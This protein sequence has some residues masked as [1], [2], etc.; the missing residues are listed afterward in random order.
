M[1][2]GIPY[3][4]SKK[5]T[6]ESFDDFAAANSPILGVRWDK[7]SSPTLTRI[8]AAKGLVANVGVD[9]GLV[10]NDFDYMPIFRDIEEVIDASGNVFIRIPRFYIRKIDAVDYKTWEVSLYQHDGFYRP[11]CFWDFANSKELPYVDIGKYKATSDGGVPDKLE[12]K[13]DLY[14]LVSQNIVTFRTRAEANGAGYQQLDIHAYDILQTLM[15]V[16]FATLNMQNVMHGY[17]SGRYSA[18]DK[19]TAITDP[20]GNIIVVSNTT[21]THYRVGQAISCGTA[22]GG[23]QRFYGRTITAIDVDTPGA[24]STTITFDGAPVVLAVDDVLFNSCWKNGYSS[25]IA[26]SSGSIGSNSDGKYPC[27]YRGI[28]SP[29][30]DIWQ[31]VDGLNIDGGSTWV[32]ATPY[33]IGDIVIGTTA[34]ETYRCTAGHTSADAT[35]PSTGADWATVW[36]LYPYRQAWVCNDANDYASNVFAAP[37]EELGY[38]NHNVNVYVRA[39]GWDAGHPYAQFAVLGDHSGS[40]ASNYYCDYYYQ[41]N[42]PRIARVGGDWRYGAIAGPWFWSLSSS[43]LASAFVFLGGQLVRKA[44]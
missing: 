44:L 27:M 10:V 26:A 15:T 19:A 12:S 13:P 38:L 28:E 22:L 1:S 5:Y 2:I 40:G 33:N 34:G 18:D 8:G 6:D 17:V 9:S 32:T 3:E 42:G 16:E 21:G 35:R 29:Y 41:N 39:K 23:V 24:G 14:P 4:M 25:A 31:F 7:G 37:Y 43:S 30:G 11:W 36:D 20:A